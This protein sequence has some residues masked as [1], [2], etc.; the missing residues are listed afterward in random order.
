MPVRS[1][2]PA[3]SSSNAIELTPPTVDKTM[4]VY[5][6]ITI[7]PAAADIMAAYGL[8][9]FSCSVGGTES[10]SDG[11]AIHGFDEE[12]TDAL[13]DDLNDA[14]R[15]QP[16]PEAQLHITKAA[17]Q[18]I[19]AIAK[20]EQK[21]GHGLLVIADAN[22]G[23]CLEFVP[24]PSADDHT[25]V[26]EAVPDVRIFASS[27]S[28]WRIGGATIDFREERFKLDL[29]GDQSDSCCGGKKDCSCS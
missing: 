21:E 8:H 12:T 1:S 11:C 7:C 23:F 24:E 4:A 9:C 15:E 10:L 29:P 14:I 16:V 26:N 6:I 3:K 22:G 2:A 5:E 28:L 18:A 25:F 17:A 27:L 19:A 13:V 20:Q